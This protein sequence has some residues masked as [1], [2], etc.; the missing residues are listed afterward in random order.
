MSFTFKGLTQAAFLASTLVLAACAGSQDEPDVV[1]ETDTG[2]ETTTTGTGQPDDVNTT[3]VTSDELDGDNA[4]GAAN[5]SGLDGFAGGDR[6]F[7]AYDSSEL[8]SDAREML[9]KQIEW[10]KHHRSARI[11]VEGHCDERGTRE[12]NLALGERRAVAVKNY[13]TAYGVSASRI[14]TISYGK[15]R[16]EVGGGGDNAWSLNRRSVTVVR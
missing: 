10:L 14:R 16:P 11:V 13:M 8:S 2:T 4:Y 7:F 1:N 3:D 12:Y 6:V 15:E 9:D 5:Q